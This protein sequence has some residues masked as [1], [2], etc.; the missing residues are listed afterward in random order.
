[1][2]MQIKSHLAG[3]LFA[4]IFGFTFMF[5]KVALDYVVPMGLI[6]YRFLVAFLFFELLR[7]LKWVN[8]RFSRAS[9]KPI[10]W[11]VFFQPVLYFLF[12]IYGLNLVTSA[13]AGMMIA[14][15]PVFGALMSGVVLKEPVR[16]V[17]WIFIILSV[18]GIVY[19]QVQRLQNGLEGA[20][21]GFILLFLA[22]LSAAAFNLAS[23]AAST[24]V[25]AAE[26]TYFMMM[27]GAVTFN[28]L[29]IGQL[30]IENRLSDYVLNL[31]IIQ[32]V[33]PILYLGVMASVGGFF[34]VNYALRTL[35]APVASIYANLATVVSILAGAFILNETLYRYHAI[36]SVIILVGVYGT[37]RTQRK[38]RLLI[39]HKT[40]MKEPL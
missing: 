22:V 9:I 33:F 27:V 37:V 23:R 17:Q 21:L 16:P 28:I 6:A 7:R 34:L 24:R 15:I 3:V 4:T 1:M 36:G 19:I 26:L 13:E 10:F 39:T 11:V 30:I 14:L 20:L 40:P 35:T 2:M 5:S 38:G 12:E 32:N 8:I 25:R 29:F 31:M 18:S